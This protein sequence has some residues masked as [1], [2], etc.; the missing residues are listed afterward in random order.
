MS[1]QRSPARRSNLNIDLWTLRDMGNAEDGLG[2]FRLLE[3]HGLWPDRIGG[4]EP[5][6]DPLP[7]GDYEKAVRYWLD[8]IVM[9]KRGAPRNYSALATWW[10]NLPQGKW[11]FNSVSLWFPAKFGRQEL[12]RI[13]QLAHDLYELLQP[14]LMH[15]TTDVAHQAQWKAHAHLHVRLQGIHWLNFFG[16][17]YCEHIGRHRLA[18]AGSAAEGLPDGGMLVRVGD[19]PFAKYFEDPH[20]P[21]VTRV[22]Q[23]IGL[24]WFAEAEPHRVPPFDFSPLWRKEEMGDRPLPT[25]DAIGPL[26]SELEVCAASCEQTL[27]AALGDSA[28]LD[29][30]SE[31]LDALEALLYRVRRGNKHESLRRC[32]GWYFGEVVRRHLGGKWEYHADFRTWGIRGVGGKETVVFPFAKI[33]KLRE[34]KQQNGLRVVFDVLRAKG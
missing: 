26:A 10:N 15:V 18:A 28:T 3:H 34:E 31:S 8:R 21:E 24:E 23:A 13:V 4:F 25:Y 29:W 30:S 32:I 11:S 9:F 1:Q 6:R 14:V 22:K 20:S 16:P 33:E 17:I 2:F 7:P 12:V 27:R 5:I 19:D